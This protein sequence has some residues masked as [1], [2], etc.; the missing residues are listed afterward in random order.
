M[1]SANSRYLYDM[2]GAFD[3]FEVDTSSVRRVEA[4]WVWYF[5]MSLL[6]ALALKDLN[7]SVCN[8]IIMHYV[9]ECTY[10]MTNL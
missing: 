2:Y 4:P 3:L 10:M 1:N 7:G 5:R 6:G 8:A 9:K